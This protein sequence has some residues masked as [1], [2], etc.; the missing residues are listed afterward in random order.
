MYVENEGDEKNRKVREKMRRDERKGPKQEYIRVG[1][2]NIVSGRGNRL[3]MACRKLGRYKIDVCILTETKLSRHHTVKSGDFKIIATKVTNTSKGGVAMLYR[4]SERF[5]IESPKC[6]GENVI[7]ATVVHGRQRTVILGIYIPPSESDEE[8]TIDLDRAMKNEDPDK[9]VII[10]DLNINYQSPSKKRDLEIA[11]TLKMYGMNDISRKFK[12]RKNKPHRWTWQQ[13]REGK[14]VRAIC[15]YI[16]SGETVEWRNFV[17]I[18]I[19]FDTDHRLL[20]AKMTSGGREKYRRYVKMRMKPSVTLFPPK[21][22]VSNSRDEQNENLRIIK[23]S[24]EEDQK[25]KEKKKSWISEKTYGV[26]RRKVKALRQ[27]DSEKIRQLGK[28]L[29][30]SLRKDRRNRIKETSTRIEEELRKKN[31]V[32]AYDILRGWYK[33]FSGRSERPSLEDLASKR[34]FYADL[35]SREE[36]EREKLEISY[37][38]NEV[39]DSIPEEKEIIEALF[40]LKN[41]KAPGLTGITVEHLKGWYRLA[42]PEDEKTIDGKAVKI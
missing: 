41:R 36:T 39:D 34:E 12:C 5:H 13:K 14:K 17:P 18:D 6:Y 10:G 2:L 9:C 35:F 28:E 7:K 24:I 25:G 23:E 16:L 37:E 4:K 40:R 20:T 11:E 19:D 38:G 42:N 8:T 33:K 22:K 21:S 1:T 15:D 29:R 32:G 31:V 27:N 3:E 30:R 26:L